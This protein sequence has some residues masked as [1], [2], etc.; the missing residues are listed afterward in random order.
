VPQHIVQDINVYD[1]PSEH[2]F[3]E[4]VRQSTFAKK[5]AQWRGEHVEKQNAAAYQA[6]Q[7]ALKRLLGPQQNLKGTGLGVIGTC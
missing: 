3:E 6:N 2:W 1:K 4:H 7:Y 5:H